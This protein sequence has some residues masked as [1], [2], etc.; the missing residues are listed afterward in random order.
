MQIEIEQIKNDQSDA[1][2]NLILPIQLVELMYLSPSKISQIYL[3]LSRIIML[4]EVCSGVPKL[5]E[6]WLAL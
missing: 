4:A 3:I 5:T 6:N 1:V 2:I